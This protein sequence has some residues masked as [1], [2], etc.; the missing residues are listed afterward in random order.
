MVPSRACLGLA[1]FPAI[2]MRCFAFLRHAFRLVALH[3]CESCFYVFSAMVLLEVLHAADNDMSVFHRKCLPDLGGVCFKGAPWGKQNNG[4]KTSYMFHMGSTGF[5]SYVFMSVC[6]VFSL[7][8][9]ISS[10]NML[11]FAL[12]TLCHAYIIH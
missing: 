10:T 6:W 9:K 1:Q 8:N 2:E 11:M 3:K 12:V 4:H 5:L 7:L